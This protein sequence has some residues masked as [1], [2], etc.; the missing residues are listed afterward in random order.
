MDQMGERDSGVCVQH[1]IFSFGYAAGVSCTIVTLE[2]S[3]SDKRF[4][5]SRYTA[6]DGDQDAKLVVE[7]VIIFPPP[8]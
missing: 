1:L 8:S 5:T 6:G 4:Q 3:L 7:N 2:L